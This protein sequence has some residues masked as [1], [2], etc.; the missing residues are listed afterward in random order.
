MV[1]FTLVVL[2]TETAVA[3]RPSASFVTFLVGLGVL[4]TEYSLL[5]ALAADLGV[6]A[7]HVVHS[8]G[9]DVTFSLVGA[10]RTCVFGAEA[11]SMSLAVVHGDGTAR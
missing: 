6:T 9:D 11:K 2:D 1:R 7:L 4:G 8:G 5:A 3:R 10:G